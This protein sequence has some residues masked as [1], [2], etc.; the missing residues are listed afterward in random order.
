MRPVDTF[1]AALPATAGLP[2]IELRFLGNR[3]E[4]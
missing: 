1:A 4:K 3:H 2:L